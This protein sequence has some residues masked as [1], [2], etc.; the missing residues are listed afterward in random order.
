MTESTFERG[1][2]NGE[3]KMWDRS[4]NI[5][6]NGIYQDGEPWDGTF[7][8]RNSSGNRVLF[9]RYQSGKLVQK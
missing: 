3:F 6:A 5:I 2:L 4:G 1:Y 7:I 8:S 9:H